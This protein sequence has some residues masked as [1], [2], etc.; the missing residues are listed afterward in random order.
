MTQCCYHPPSY[1]TAMIELA[2]TLGRRGLNRQDYALPAQFVIEK[3]ISSSRI[4]ALY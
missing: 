4:I 3:E 2:G 1:Q